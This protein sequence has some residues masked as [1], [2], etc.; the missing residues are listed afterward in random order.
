MHPYIVQWI[1]HEYDGHYAL[2]HTAI[3]PDSQRKIQD[4]DLSGT[5]TK[6]EIWRF[7]LKI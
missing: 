4:F 5:S 6:Q 7:F 2:E 1:P 3:Q